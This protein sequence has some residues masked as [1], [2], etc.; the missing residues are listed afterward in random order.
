M[1]NVNQEN[2]MLIRE[3]RISAIALHGDVVFN[4]EIAS[5]LERKLL[6]QMKVL[7]GD[8][9]MIRFMLYFCL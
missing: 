5:K 6:S 7:S 8:K 3:F 2:Q 1:E 4:S 9:E